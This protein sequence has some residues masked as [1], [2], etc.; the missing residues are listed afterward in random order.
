MSRKLITLLA[1]PTLAVL[2]SMVGCG[3]YR[4][5]SRTDVGGTVALEGPPESARAKAE[6]YIGSQC[7]FGY[8]LVPDMAPSVDRTML[9]TY[10][11]KT[12]AGHPQAVAHSLRVSF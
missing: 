9:I 10:R 6:D 5:V 8:E 2:A 12:P 3:G 4:V 11:C 1:L 7:P